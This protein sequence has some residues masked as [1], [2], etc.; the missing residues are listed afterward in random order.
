MPRKK[1]GVSP[2]A[3]RLTNE[4][5]A[6]WG[7]IAERAP[8]WGFQCAI[9]AARLFRDEAPYRP[10]ELDDQQIQHRNKLFK[11]FGEL[12]APIMAKRDSDAL[13]ALADLVDMLEE[14]EVIRPNG[15]RD[16][17]VGRKEECIDD[18]VSLCISF[19]LGG[20]RNGVT[21]D[22][23]HAAIGRW[24]LSA[25]NKTLRTKA[26]ALGLPVLA[27]PAGRPRTV[28]TKRRNPGGRAIISKAE[29]EKIHATWRR[30]GGHDWREKSG[31][32]R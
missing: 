16:W 10:D 15:K 13:R 8:Q 7:K 23:L 30:R 2:S 26:R 5:A 11:L 21:I 18:K 27:K 28:K 3:G 29:K 1:S 22:Q 24:K 25:D 6:G 14:R 9:E 20:E 19:E 12:F 31:K 32:K 17:R 4:I